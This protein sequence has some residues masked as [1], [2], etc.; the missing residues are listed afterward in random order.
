LHLLASSFFMQVHA[1]ANDSLANAPVA[2]TDIGDMFRKVFKKKMDTIKVTKSRSVAILPSIG[3]N[4][5]MGF[6]IGAKS[7]AGFQKGDPRTTNYSII[8]IEFLYG[9]NGILTLQARHNI[10]NE[11]NR[12]NL[13]GNW[14]LSKYGQVDYGLGTGNGNYLSRG[15]IINEFP[16]ANGDSAF[17]LK[18]Q[19]IRLQEKVYR[20]IGKHWFAGAGISFDFFSKIKDERLAGNAA[21]TL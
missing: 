8:G 13:Q 20:K 21:P 2:Q 15:F 9:S 5:S 4:P 12:W 17:P 1:Q 16:T 11:N 6:I 3:Y 14:Q 18:Y 7:S 10:F 19:Y